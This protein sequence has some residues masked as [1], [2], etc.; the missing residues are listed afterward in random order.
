M[1]WLSLLLLLLVTPSFVEASERFPR[2][3]AVRYRAFF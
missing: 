2:G 1:T 3:E